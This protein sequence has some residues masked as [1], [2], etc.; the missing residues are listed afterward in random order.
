MNTSL[1]QGVEEEEGGRTQVSGIETIIHQ[2]CIQMSMLMTSATPVGMYSTLSS[3]AFFYSKVM[4]TIH[5][6]HYFPSSYDSYY[7]SSL[8]QFVPMFKY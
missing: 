3:V 7:T 5:L 2:L 4:Y 6:I 1:R 8:C